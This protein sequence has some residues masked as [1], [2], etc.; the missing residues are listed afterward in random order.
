MQEMPSK[1]IPDE[2]T[3]FLLEVRSRGYTRR[4]SRPKGACFVLRGPQQASLLVGVRTLLLSGAV[5]RCLFGVFRVS[6]CQ[7]EGAT[8]APG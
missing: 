2:G 6:L 4:G 8:T 3:F 5:L 7:N 1:H